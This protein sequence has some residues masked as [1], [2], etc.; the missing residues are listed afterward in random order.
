MLM[1]TS[2]TIDAPCT[3]YTLLLHVVCGDN[4][5]IDVALHIPN[6][7]K[8]LSWAPLLFPFPVLLAYSYFGMKILL[9]HTPAWLTRLCILPVILAGKRLKSFL[10]EST[11]V[12]SF[13]ILRRLMLVLRLIVTTF[14]LLN[15]VFQCLGFVE[16]NSILV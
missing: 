4:P 10:L 15:G 13:P 2:L 11:L 7:A 1:A 5:S 8:V 12:L 14:I 6:I 9:M 3:L 16:L